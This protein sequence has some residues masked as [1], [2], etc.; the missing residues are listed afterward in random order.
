MHMKFSMD[1]KTLFVK[2]EIF[3]QSEIDAFKTEVNERF[4][5]QQ[6]QISEIVHNQKIMAAKQEEMAVKQEEISAK[7]D[8]MS[9]DLKAILA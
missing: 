7:Q 8:A 2:R 5:S 4:S 1:P 6:A 9:A 3:E